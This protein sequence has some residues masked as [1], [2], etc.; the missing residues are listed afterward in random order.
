MLLLAAV[1]LAVLA[2][3]MVVSALIVCGFSMATVILAPVMARAGEAIG[4]GLEAE[5][6]ACEL[7]E[8]L[9]ALSDIT[10]V[11]GNEELLENIF[12]R[13]CIGK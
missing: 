12:S 10:G 1:S 2:A 3:A 7:R 4:D 6:V 5:L 9:S 13:F 8:A 11:T